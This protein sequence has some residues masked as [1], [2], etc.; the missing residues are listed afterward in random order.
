M[1]PLKRSEAIYVLTGIEDGGQNVWEGERAI[2]KHSM[3]ATI[4][5]GNQGIRE[6]VSHDFLLTMFPS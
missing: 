1:S 2:E 5:S 6:S 4:I 3:Y